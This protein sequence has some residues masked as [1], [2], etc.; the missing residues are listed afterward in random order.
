MNSAL[1]QE[2]VW[3][4]PA[5]AL[6]LVSG[7]GAL[8]LIPSASGLL[9]ALS[10]LPAW[11]ALAVLIAAVSA[12]VGAARRKV[13]SPLTALREWLARDWRRAVMIAGIMLLAGANMIAF[14]WVKPLLNYLVPFHADPLLADLDRALFL[15]H[16]PWAVLEWLAFPAA[17]VIYHPLWFTAMVFALLLTASAPP[18]PERSA[19]LLSYFILWSVVGPMIHTLLPAAGPIFYERM[20]YGT[21]FAGLDGGPETREVA[22]YLWSIYAS[23]SFG[24]GSGIS[25]M[26]SLHVTISSWIV[27]A[28]HVFA[29]RWR[30]VAL[31][32]WGVIFAL[33]IAL[34]WHYALDGIVGAVAAA[35]CYRVALG[36]MRRGGARR[37]SPLSPTPP[38]IGR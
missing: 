35:G 26:P 18:S 11:M 38:D 24:A 12:F 7:V 14:M 32:A 9:P 31:T 6:T 16:E 29:R 23:K 13:D 34:G 22:D 5:A 36:I 3:L 20:G 8:A 27:I 15:G 25:A 37:L 17:G 21:R 2:R 1:H 33:S 19:V 30:W 28:F 10:I 4:A